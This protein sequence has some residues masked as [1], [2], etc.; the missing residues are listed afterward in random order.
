MATEHGAVN[1][2]PHSFVLADLFDVAAMTL[3]VPDHIFDSDPSLAWVTCPC[4]DG[5]MWT[6][7]TGNGWTS[8]LFAERRQ[9]YAYRNL[10]SSYKICGRCNGS[11][12]VL[13]LATPE[14]QIVLVAKNPRSTPVNTTVDVLIANVET[15]LAAYHRD[16]ILMDAL[17]G[18]R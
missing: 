15:L 7:Q 11:G 17:Q 1:D 16:A 5:D 3:E 8:A 9:A 12:E 4:C 13:D 6:Q 2:Q 14:F 10:N 18:R